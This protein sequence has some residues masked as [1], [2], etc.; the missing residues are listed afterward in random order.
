[1][2]ELIVKFIRLHSFYNCLFVSVERELTNKDS[3]SS[4]LK[5]NSCFYVCIFVSL[6]DIF[7]FLTLNDCNYMNHSGLISK[8]PI[9]KV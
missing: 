7:F 4:C 9:E 8:F 3:Y 1:M 2:M 6:V 5:K